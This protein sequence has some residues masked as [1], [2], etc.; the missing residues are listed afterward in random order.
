MDLVFDIKE[1]GIIFDTKL[2]FS[3]LTEIIKNKAMRNLDFI[4]RTC[5]TFSD[6]FHLKMFY[7]SLVR[8]NL[9]YCPLSW[10]NNTLKQNTTLESVQNNFCTIYFIQI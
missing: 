10:I 2:N 1:L 3:L 8:S 9:D 7:F 5:C 4:K 6:P